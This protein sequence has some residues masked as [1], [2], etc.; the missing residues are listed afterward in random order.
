[1]NPE[2]YDW[3]PIAVHELGHVFAHGY[4]GH[5]VDKVEVG[6]DYGRTHL[7]DQTMNAFEYLIACCSGKAAVDRWFGWKSEPDEAWA[8][9]DDHK[10]A[11]HAALRVSEGD[12]SAAAI[13]L[14]WAERM[15]DTLIERHWDQFPDAVRALCERATLR[16]LNGTKAA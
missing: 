15:A 14:R 3:E 5:K 1:M 7:P 8:Q 16:I 6:D 9:S 10:R 12:H 4:F 11:Y 13:L 2:R